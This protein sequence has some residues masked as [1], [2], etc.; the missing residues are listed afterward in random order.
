MVWVVFSRCKSCFGCWQLYN[1]LMDVKSVG[2]ACSCLCPLEAAKALFTGHCMVVSIMDHEVR[3]LLCEVMTHRERSGSFLL[4]RKL[5]FPF[6]CS[7]KLR[8]KTRL[9]ILS[10]R[11]TVRPSAHDF[12]Q[13]ILRRQKHSKS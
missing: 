3:N 7:L 8:Q 2:K 9:L 6:C 5:R 11:M 13:V 12:L 10:L 1:H 4:R